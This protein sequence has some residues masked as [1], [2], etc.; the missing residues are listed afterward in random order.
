MVHPIVMCVSGPAICYKAVPPKSFTSLG[1][2]RFAAMRDSMVGEATST[3][4]MSIPKKEADASF[5]AV[6][7]CSLANKH[8]RHSVHGL[9]KTSP[10]THLQIRIHVIAG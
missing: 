7:S 4:D 5:S 9:V 3:S 10:K 8:D 6:D 1:L 2:C